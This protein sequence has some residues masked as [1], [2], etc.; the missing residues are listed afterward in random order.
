M[1]AWPPCTRTS[2]GA[3]AARDGATLSVL[4][5][6]G[7]CAFGR[8]LVDEAFT[9]LPDASTIGATPEHTVCSTDRLNNAPTSADVRVNLVHTFVN[10]LCKYPEE[11]SE[12]ADK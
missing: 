6:S 12:R 11:G 10:I 8:Q 1:W 9:Q 3:V 7:D 5:K 4:V 2:S